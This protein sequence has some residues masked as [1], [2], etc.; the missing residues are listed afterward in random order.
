[1]EN[2][3]NADRYFDLIE[4]ENSLKRYLKELYLMKDRIMYERY[5]AELINIQK[6]LVAYRE[7]EQKSIFD[8][9]I[10]FFRK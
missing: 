9:I 3:L 4:R 7:E 1:M 8:I 5:R 2:K 10:D 6:E